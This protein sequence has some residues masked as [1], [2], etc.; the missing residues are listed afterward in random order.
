MAQLVIGTAG[1]IDHGKTALVKALTGIDTDRLEEEIARGMTIDL[2][3][4]FLSDQVTIIDVPGHE[5]FI[6]NMVAGVSTI[7]LALLIIAA[8]DGIMPQTIEHFN[9]LKIL[10]VPQGIIALTK[11]DLVNDEEWLELIEAEIEELVAGSFLESAP[12]IR[13]AAPTEFG[14]EELRQ[15]IIQESQQALQVRDR[16]FFRHQVDR[17]F[18]KKG[19]GAVVT[20][21]VISCTTIPGAELRIQPGD[22]KTKIRSIQSHGKEVDEVR[23]G[24]RA[25]INLSGTDLEMIRRGSELVETGWL[26]ETKTLIA[27]VEILADTRWELKHQQR[28][29]VHIGTTELLG[30][31]ALLKGNRLKPGATGNIIVFCEE[32]VVAAMDDRFVFRSYSPMETIGGGIIID[33]A[34]DLKGRQLRDWGKTLAPEPKTRFRQFI[35]NSRKNPQSLD[36]WSRRFNT[37]T[38]TISSWIKELDLAKIPDKELLFDPNDK[39]I[40]Q[41]EILEYLKVFHKK[42]PYRK[43]LSREAV[44]NELG[45]SQAWFDFLVADLIAAGKVARAQAGIALSEHEINLKPEDQKSADQIERLLLSGRFA[46]PSLTDLKNETGLGP[47]KILELLHILKENELA[48]EIQ[49]GLW[50][51]ISWVI[52]LE[53]I[54]KKYFQENSELQVAK[55]KSL[56]ET[57]RKT[58]IPLLEYCDA[59]QLTF[60][61]GDY[62]EAGKRLA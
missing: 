5:R 34:P 31:I 19:F 44:R 43:L 21:T 16:G 61:V 37:G 39:L 45:I 35:N 60:R 48:V 18:I 2:G 32:P 38:D 7:H 59:N 12:I 58:A 14:I 23:L 51:H 26:K 41:F 24:D 49:T 13:T 56:T 1:H 27:Q 25:A 54:L 33:P 57:T 8:D 30:R 40:D 47:A 36:Q 62:R 28:V 46:P 4:A 6:R 17:V 9:I 50:Y 55:F 22:I 15:T 3:F 10:G 53:T 11:T 29:H 42:N 20:G 52:K